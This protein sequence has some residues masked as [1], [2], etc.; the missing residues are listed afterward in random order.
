MEELETLEKNLSLLLE[1][2]QALQAENNLLKEESERQREEVM[3]TH[4]ELVQIKQQ[5]KSLQVAHA[6][7]ATSENR[8]KAYQ[9]LT[10]M[11]SR[12]DSAIDVLKQ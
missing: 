11:I 9:Y 7:T 2:Y 8:D 4:A 10:N 3:Q 12:V 5:Y 6:M 1:K